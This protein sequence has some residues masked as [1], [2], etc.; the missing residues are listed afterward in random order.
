MIRADRG[1]AVVEFVLCLPVIVALF[2]APLQLLRLWYRQ[3][4]LERRAFDLAR[5]L[6]AEAG[7]GARLSAVAAA[8]C[9]AGT[10]VAVRVLQPP[11]ALAGRRPRRWEAV[12]VSLGEAASLGFPLPSSVPLTARARDLRL[13]ETP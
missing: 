13:R 4:A 1:N 7:D 11:V 10:T 9:G 5:A 12:E 2:V 3:F 8:L 6:G